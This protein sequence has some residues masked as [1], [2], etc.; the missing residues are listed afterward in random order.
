MEL[1]PKN[2]IAVFRNMAVDA[3]VKIVSQS[4]HDYGVM[5]KSEQKWFQQTM[6][7]VLEGYREPPPCLISHLR[8]EAYYI[9]LLIDLEKL[10]D[11]RFEINGQDLSRKVTSLLNY[12]GIGY[13]DYIEESIALKKR[14]D[15]AVLKKTEQRKNII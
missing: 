10:N 8:A 15:E 14:N 9:Q 1:E 11:K 13:S 2:L 3:I 6:E 4:G 5:D 12:Y 7:Y